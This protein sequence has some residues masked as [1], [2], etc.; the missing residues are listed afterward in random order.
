MCSPRSPAP[1]A[2]AC[3]AARFELLCAVFAAPPLTGA[4]TTIEDLW[5]DYTLYPYGPE[6]HWGGGARM[7]LHFCTLPLKVAVSTHCNAPFGFV[8]LSSI[9]LL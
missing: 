3:R 9:R 1:L 2:A 6:E 4:I 5:V 7:C 8:T